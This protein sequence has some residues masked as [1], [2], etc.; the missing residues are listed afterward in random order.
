[1]TPADNLARD[2]IRTATDQTLFV[3]AGA[4]S[5]KTQAL[6]DRVTT[7]VL[8]D[9]V[10]LAEVA[11][12]TFT[13]KAGAEL[14]DRLRGRFEPIGQ[15]AGEPTHARA[16]Q[17]L[18]DLDTAAI[19]TLHSFAQRILASYPIEAGLPPVIEVL[20]EVGSSVAFADRWSTLQRVLLDDDEVAEPLLLAL[21]LGVKLDHIR[22]LVRA[23]GNDWDLIQERIIDQP[24][25][26][27]EVPELDGLLADAHAVV[28]LSGHCT[29]DE[30]R[31]LAHLE[32]LREELALLAATDDVRV[33]LGGLRR[34]SQISF[35]QG[36]KKSWGVD[37]A[38][39]RARGA[40]V[41]DL[42]GEV[43]AVVVDRCL[44]ILVRWAGQQVLAAAEERRREGRLEFH[45]LLVLTRELLRQ[46]PAVR[47]AMHQQYQRLLLDE[48]QDTDPIQIE[49]AVRI[50]AGAAAEQDNWQDVAVP[51]GR[52]FFVGDAKQS[53]YRFRRAD[54][55]TYLQA[56]RRLGRRLTLYTNFRTVAPV[57]QWVNGVFVSLIEGGEGQPSYEPLAPHRWDA[58][59][60]PAVTVLGV[61]AHEDKPNADEIRRREAADVAA[62]VQRALRDGWQVWDARL[63]AEGGWR[64]AEHR[65]IAVLVPARTSL[66]FL[67]DA[68]DGA[69]IPFR[70]EASSLVYQS[71]E[72]RELFAAARAVAD[73]TDELSLVMALRSPLF[74]CGDD[75]LWHWRHAGGRIRIWSRL[76]DEHP[77]AD[78]PVG[79]ALSYLRG[80][81]RRARWLQP[82]EVLAALV[83]DRRMMEVAAAR[84][85]GRDV[86]RRVRFVVDQARAWQEVSSGGLRAYLA[87]A[88]FQAQEAT[89]V[90]EAVLPE[91]DSDA[92]HAMTI[93]AAKGLE[94]P[95]VV[96]SGLSSQSMTPR[97]VRLLWRDGGYQV[98]FGSQVQTDDF[99]EAAPVD[100]QMD[101]LEKRR[102]LYVA[103]TRARDHLVVSLHR[104][105]GQ[106]TAAS[107]L[108]DAGAAGFGA[109]HFSGAAQPEDGPASPPRVEPPPDWDE[110][111]AGV[112][113]AR[114]ESATVHTVSASGLEGTEPEVELGATEAPDGMAKGPRDLELPPWSKGRY[115]SAVGRAVHGVLQSVDLATGAGLEAAVEAQVLAEGVLGQADLV[116][117]LVR[118]ALGSEL[119]QRAAAREHWQESYVGTVQDDGRVLEGYVDLIF[120]EDDG[121]LVVVDYKTDAVPPGGIDSRVTY[122][123]P[124]MRAY[125][126]C[127]EAA[128]GT[129]VRTVLLFLHPQTAVAVDV[130]EAGR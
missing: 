48:F 4:G 130:E 27:L 122:Y 87:W 90:A 65:D 55:A 100:E 11:A 124:Q 118:S 58:V 28:A 52:L 93:H 10:R 114:D 1:M 12:V 97:G 94:F 81:A 7:L 15:D 43:V 77:L 57:L 19:G 104:R 120:R 89:R 59:E 14:R 115:G 67:E 103:A 51:E 26:V 69:G 95:I 39:V 31:L 128:T 99:A 82:S 116:R 41:R 3:N 127:L 32:T 18:D 96:V 125:R 64:A 98:R 111:L 40:G 45:D 29:D 88:A 83:A 84:P 71:E 73:S 38:E 30:D 37:V 13:E 78:G 24:P 60:G 53:I 25:T 126:S 20:D 80:L 108:A 66:P 9:G 119:V 91:T 62:A 56:E 107:L 42:A 85:R 86:W 49:L 76:Q 75:D 105:P 101:G 129:A 63:G 110:W 70:A 34:I 8:E 36:K 23:L 2:T 54:I 68:L 17:A 102:L 61:E 44:R 113:A 106:T 33:R 22:S 117:D 123:A 5:G 92:V 35:T 74:G 21:A 16:Q 112:Q 109:H 6:V 46:Q 50:A 121:T 47:D 79:S 72:I